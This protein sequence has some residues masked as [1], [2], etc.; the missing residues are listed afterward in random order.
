MPTVALAPQRAE[1]VWLLVEHDTAVRPSVRWELRGIGWVHAVL[2]TATRA[3]VLGS[4]IAVFL[5]D[6]HGAERWV[7]R[8]GHRLI[9]IADDVRP[10]W[11]RTFAPVPSIALLAGVC[12]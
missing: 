11:K 3:G 10:G 4:T 12:G 8:V 5:V 1:R 2:S 9:V 7:V 6:L